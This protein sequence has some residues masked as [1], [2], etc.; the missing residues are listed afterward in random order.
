[1]QVVSICR[2]LVHNA[3]HPSKINHMTAI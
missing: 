3:L 1:M 2:V